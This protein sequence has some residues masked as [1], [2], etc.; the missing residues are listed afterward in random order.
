MDW[1]KWHWTRK[2]TY[3]SWTLCGV[4]IGVAMEGGTFLPET[5]DEPSK[6]DCKR[7]KKILSR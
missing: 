4:I 1:T 6:V 7:C 3:S 5:D 2:G